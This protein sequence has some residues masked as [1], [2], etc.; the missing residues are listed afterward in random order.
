MADSSSLIGRT[1]SH[2]RVIEKLGVGGMGVV[3]KAQDTRLDRA[4]ALKFLPDDVAH[5]ANALE[6]FKR[7]AKATSALNHPN[8]CTIYDVGEEGGHTFIAMEYLDGMTQ[9]QRI[10]SRP[11]ETDTLLNLAIEIADGLDAAHAESIVHRDI[12]PANIF[13]T[14]RGHAKILD[15]GLAKLQVKVGT[16][17]DAT[18]TQEAKQLSTPGAAMG[19]LAYMSP[20]QARGKELDGRPD[21]FSFGL[22]LYEMTT[23]RQTFSGNTSAELFDAIL[24]RTPVAPVRLNPEV[25]PKLEDIIGKAL[26]KDRKL[27]YQS[28]A[29]MRT[30]L[31]RLKRDTESGPS[32]AEAMEAEP[33]PASSVGTASP[34]PTSPA[35]THALSWPKLAGA[36]AVVVISLAVAVWLYVARRAHALT[37]KDTIVLADFTNTTGDPV[38]D[39]TLRQGLSVQLEQ[40][41]FLKTISDQQI[42]QVLKM[43]GQKSDATLTPETARELCQRTASV[44]G[45]DGPHATC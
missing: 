23:G 10:G 7:E 18:L 16:D 13:V 35:K 36:A 44:A 17:A 9:K 30:D 31:Q 26:E 43:M 32:A 20:E 25:P 45:L 5:D 8:I 4:V 11:I 29:E 40:S 33:V 38:F 22:V 37:D 15:F 21:I 34:A 19:T 39:G 2:Y 6:R 14:K 28:A 12:K 42:Q 3:F 27:R 1:V 24:N 41:P